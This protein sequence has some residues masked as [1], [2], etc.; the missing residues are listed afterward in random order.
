MIEGEHKM[1]DRFQDTPKNEKA[2][3]VVSVQFTQNATW[4]GNITWTEQKKTV[5]FRSALEMLKLMDDAVSAA[6]DAE[7]RAKWD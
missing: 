7:A 5:A 1:N 4:Q 2:T 6:P 3:F